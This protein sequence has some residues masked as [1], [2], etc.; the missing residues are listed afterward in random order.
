[1]D[2]MDKVR[3]G[4]WLNYHVLQGNP[5]AIDPNFHVKDRIGRKDRYLAVHAIETDELGLNAFGV[6]SI[7]FHNAPICFGLKANSILLINISADF[8]FSER[9]GFPFPTRREFVSE[10]AVSYTHLTLPTIYSV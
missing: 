10:G 4:L 7:V 2:W 3:V 1:M 6:E 9:A 5:T 8:I